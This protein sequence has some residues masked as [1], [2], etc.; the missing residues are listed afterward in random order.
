[1]KQKND[2][3][4]F[5]C[6]LLFIS[7]LINGCAKTMPLTKESKDLSLNNESIGILHL[8]ISNNLAKSYQPRVDSINIIKTNSGDN[9]KFKAEKPFKQVKD[10]Y[11][12]YLF[13]FKLSPGKYKIEEVKGEAGIFSFIGHFQFPINAEFNLENNVIAYLGYIEMINRKRKGG[14]MWSGNLIPLLDQAVTGFSGGTFDITVSDN[15]LEDI[16]LFKE[17]YPLIN[18][19]EIKHNLAAKP[20]PDK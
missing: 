15:Y 19:Y 14:E 10:E 16:K 8:K 5:I 12:E 11:N 2:H 6:A 3:A 20:I 4:L 13:S 17:H 18:N 9:I 7:I 1:M